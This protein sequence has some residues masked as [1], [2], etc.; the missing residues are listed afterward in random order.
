[1]T[2]SQTTG[3]MLKNDA[4]EVA[5]LNAADR[6]QAKCSHVIVAHPQ[7]SQFQYDDGREDNYGFLVKDFEFSITMADPATGQTPDSISTVDVENNATGIL[8]YTIP[9]D[10][11]PTWHDSDTVEGYAN[12]TKL[13]I[14]GYSNDDNPMIVTHTLCFQFEDLSG[15]EP[16]LCAYNWQYGPDSTE[17]ANDATFEIGAVHTQTPTADDWVPY[18]PGESCSTYEM[19]TL[20]CHN[21]NRLN[22]RTNMKQCVFVGWQ[23]QPVS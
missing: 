3:A 19:K 4:W 7:C 17:D 14:G 15:E 18:G 2:L 20:L 13:K 9:D 11:T 8:E 21:N 10:D 12:G 5:D 1:M 6:L 22:Y 23:G 16:A